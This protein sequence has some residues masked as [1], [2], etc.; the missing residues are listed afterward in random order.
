MRLVILSDTHSHH[1]RLAIPD[2]D[3][4]IHAGDMTNMGALHELHDFNEWLGTL[5]HPHKVVIAGNHDWC[6]ERDKAA[7]LKILTHAYYLEDSAMTIEGI[8]IWGTPWQPEFHHWA[9]NLPRG[10]ALREKWALIAPDTDILIT[11]GPPL[12]QGDRTM[13]WQQVGCADL[14]DVVK[15]LKPRLH[16]FG[17]I[18]EGYG[19]SYNGSTTFINASIC[20]L[21][22]RPKN[23]VTVVDW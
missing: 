15:T 20:E 8:R 18:H 4:L 7:A 14:M 22:N 5:P 23:R 3:I 11:H 1:R 17:H 9:F 6:W 19:V 13:L 21:F 2:G 12:G 16:I 10:N